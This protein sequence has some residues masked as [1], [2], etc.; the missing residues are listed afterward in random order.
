MKHDI[1]NHFLPVDGYKITAILIQPEEPPG[2][3]VIVHGYG[4]NKE[5]QL[6]L[7]RQVADAALVACVIDLRGHGGTLPLTKRSVTNV[8]NNKYLYNY[9]TVN[10]KLRHVTTLFDGN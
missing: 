9:A 4:G 2:A 6:G 3:A 5:E 8:C 10:N 1:N 7:G